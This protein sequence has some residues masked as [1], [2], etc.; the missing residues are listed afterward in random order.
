MTTKET[1]AALAAAH[2]ARFMED[3]TPATPRQI[4]FLSAIAR[5]NGI[6]TQEIED[7]IESYNGG[8]A[9]GLDKD[10][11]ALLIETFATPD[12]HAERRARTGR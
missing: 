3:A 11:A 12:N 4:G 9:W 8:H 7:M 2:T 10:C 1:L 6:A 5:K